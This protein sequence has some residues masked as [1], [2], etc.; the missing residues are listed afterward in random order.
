MKSRFD[1]LALELIPGT[2]E[3]VQQFADREQARWARVIRDR[4]IRL[5]F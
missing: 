1:T 3:E 4:N 2:P 5:D